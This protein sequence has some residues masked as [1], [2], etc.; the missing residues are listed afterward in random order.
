MDRAL[1]PRQ[2]AT[3][4]IPVILACGDAIG[5]HLLLNQQMDGCR[6]GVQFPTSPPHLQI[7]PPGRQVG[8]RWSAKPTSERTFG[9]ASR[10]ILSLESKFFAVSP[11]G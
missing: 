5:N 9:S 6:T 1:F 7:A 8:R 2:E 10:A 3:G 4:S 11:N